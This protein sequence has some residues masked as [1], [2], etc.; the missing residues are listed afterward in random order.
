TGNRDFLA[1]TQLTGGVAAADHGRNTQ[2][3]CDDR[4]VAGPPAT[5]GHDGAGA[6]H[7]RLPV[8][9]GHVGYQYVAWLYLVH[10]GYVADHLD[11]T[12]ADALTDGTTFDQDG[13][14]VLEQVALHDVDVAAALDG[15]G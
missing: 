1:V 8:G 9:I 7:H 2:L 6:L 10:F 13:A 11:R 5:V 14:L 3:T 4:R 12:G 15:L